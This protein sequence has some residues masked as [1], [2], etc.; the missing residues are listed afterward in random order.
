MTVA[1]RIVSVAFLVPVLWG[2]AN[3]PSDALREQR[4]QAQK[5]Q[6]AANE[7]RDYIKANYTKNEFLVKTLSYFQYQEEVLH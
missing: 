4:D 2:Q 3:S 6:R 1:A 5:A 7:R